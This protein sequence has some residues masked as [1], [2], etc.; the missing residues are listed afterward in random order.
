MMMLTF[1]LFVSSTICLYIFDDAPIQRA[2]MVEY[3]GR[4]AS[5]L[6]TGRAEG[7]F[8]LSRLKGRPNLFGVG[9]VEGLDGEITIWDSRLLVTRVREQRLEPAEGWNH[10]AIFLVWA[11]VAR[12]VDQPIP[13]EIRTQGQLQQL[14]RA[15]AT[16]AGIDPDDPFPFRVTGRVASLEWHVNVDRTDGQPIDQ[17]RFERSKERFQETDL[18]VEILGFHSTAHAGVFIKNSSTDANQ[19][20]DALHLHVRP[21]NRPGVTGHVDRLTLGKGM[22]LSLPAINQ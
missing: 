4:Q 22:T 15:K 13:D 11:E 5:I 14:V 21:Q 10:R 2:G 17:R 19:P 16:E 7:V 1:F 9:A 12:W 18:M 20:P 6:E 3:V 8:N